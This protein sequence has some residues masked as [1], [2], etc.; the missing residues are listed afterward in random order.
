MQFFNIENSSKPFF[1][2]VIKK[3]PHR[4]PG[5]G[6]QGKNVLSAQHLCSDV[7]KHPRLIDDE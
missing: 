3:P 1:H 4:K 7:E 5:K 6:E 2:G